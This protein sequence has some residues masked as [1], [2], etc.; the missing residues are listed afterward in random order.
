MVHSSRHPLLLIAALLILSAACGLIQPQPSDPFADQVATTVAQTLTAMPAIIASTNSVQPA[1]TESI[2][3]TVTST[4]PPTLPPTNTPAAKPDYACDITDQ[5]P[6]DDIVF[7][8]NE[9][10]DLKWTLANT[11]TQRWE[12]GTFLQ[13]Q[14]GP[15]MT[16]VLRIELPRLRPGEEY[17]V[18]MEAVAPDELDRQVMVWTVYGPGGDDDYVLCNPYVRIIV[19]R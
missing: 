5:W 1:P 11:G 6:L 8:R 13:Y 7:Q 9:A 10:F 4:L 12:E 16:E 14:N 19:E 2:R 18:I 15:E 17:D 3:P